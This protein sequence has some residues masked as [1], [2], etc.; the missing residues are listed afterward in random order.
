MDAR[1]QRLFQGGMGGGPQSAVGVDTPT[2]D[3]AEVVH[4][5]SLALLKVCFALRSPGRASPRLAP[6]PIPK[7]DAMESYI[8]NPNS[9]RC[10]S[11][12][13]LVYPWK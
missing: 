9:C 6:L 2:V 13:E 4:I 3:T 11:M 12:E 7:L 5:S 1:F 8:N 10:S